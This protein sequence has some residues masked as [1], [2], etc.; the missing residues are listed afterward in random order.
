MTS[1]VLPTIRSDISCVTDALVNL[2]VLPNLE[3]AA[4]VPDTVVQPV[5]DADPETS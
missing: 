3:L 4:G 5:I 2:S 1:Y